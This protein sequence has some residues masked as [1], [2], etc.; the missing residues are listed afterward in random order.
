MHTLAL[1]DAGGVRQAAD[2]AEQLSR[3]GLAVEGE[4]ET[5]RSGWE[6]SKVCRERIND[7]PGERDRAVAGAGLR[8]SETCP[9]PAVG[10]EL[11]VDVHLATQEVDAVHGQPEQLAL[12]HSCARSQHDERSQR[13]GHRFTKGLDLLGARWHHSRS[14]HL[15]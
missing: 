11:S 1:G 4:H 10:D 12:P 2:V 13:L 5:V 3:D 15:R 8:W 9:R 14:F 7:D 6:R